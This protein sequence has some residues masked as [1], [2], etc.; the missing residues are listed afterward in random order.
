MRVSAA[1]MLGGEEEGFFLFPSLAFDLQQ[2]PFP[3]SISGAP[4]P[5][6]R[7]L[8]GISSSILSGGTMAAHVLPGSSMDQLQDPVKDNAMFEAGID[9]KVCCGWPNGYSK[10]ALV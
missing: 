2:G 1:W 6:S 4:P 5:P 9:T 7:P 10:P 3:L 8:A